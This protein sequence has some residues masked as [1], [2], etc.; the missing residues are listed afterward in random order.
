MK[1]IIENEPMPNNCAEC[2]CCRHDSM[3][4]IQMM[5]CN[6]TFTLVPDSGYEQRMDN[7]PLK[8]SQ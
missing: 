4:G 2:P 5:Q 7:C 3:E 1:L 6:V 8:E